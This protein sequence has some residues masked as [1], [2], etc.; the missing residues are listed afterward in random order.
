MGYAQ[1]Q[2][3]LESGAL[4]TSFWGAMDVQVPVGSHRKVQELTRAGCAG[5]HP[6][7]PEAGG[8]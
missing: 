2:G 4:V 8:L 5:T 1:Y 6:Q 7:Y 3:G